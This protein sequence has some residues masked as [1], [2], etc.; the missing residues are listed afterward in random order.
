MWH[1]LSFAQSRSFRFERL[2]QKLEKRWHFSGL[3][4]YEPPG[5]F[6]VMVIVV[7]SVSDKQT[8]SKF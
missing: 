5:T 7:P 2:R 3:S 8:I 4:M 6:T 1:T